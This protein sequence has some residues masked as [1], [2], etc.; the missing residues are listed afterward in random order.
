MFNWF[1]CVACY[2]KTMEDGTQKKVR[3]PYL[4]D[5]LS[6][7]EAEARFIEEVKPFIAGEFEIASIARYKVAELFFNSEGDRYFEAEVAFITLNE[8][9]G[10]EKRTKCKVLIQASDIDQARKTLVEGMKGTLA[11]YANT[12][13]KETNIMD[14]SPY[15]GEIKTITL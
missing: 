6:F 11:D 14:V 15:D 10:R 8:K 3:E 2:D 1:K 9:N 13:I 5:A 12:A 7:T 4:I